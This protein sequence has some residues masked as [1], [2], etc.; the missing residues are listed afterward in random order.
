MYAS[1]AARFEQSY[2]EIADQVEIPGRSDPKA[3][4]FKLVYNWLR[5]EKKG[6]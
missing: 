6:E 4:I 5:D 2:R 3:N 1:N